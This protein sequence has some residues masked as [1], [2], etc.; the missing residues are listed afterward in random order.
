MDVWLQ[1]MGKDLKVGE[2]I[3]LKLVQGPPIQT[4][5][6][7]VDAKAAP[8]AFP[9]ILKFPVSTVTPNFTVAPW[10][11]G[12]LYQQDIPKPVEDSD[13]EDNADDK[14][15]KKRWKY[16]R[17]QAAKRQ[18]ILQEQVDFLETM[19]HRREAKKIKSTAESASSTN[20]SSSSSSSS[21]KSLSSRYEGVPE[22][23]A[24]QYVLLSLQTA[25]TATSNKNG[26]AD[27]ATVLV[28]H[29]PTPES[30]IAFQQPAARRTLT[31]SQAEQAIQDQRAGI[32]TTVRLPPLEFTKDQNKP[33]VA[34]LRIPPTKKNNSQSR[35]LQKLQKA[36]TSTDDAMEDGDDV[37]ADVT[38]RS[39][40]G[41]SG[42]GGGRNSGARR[43]LL[44]T[45]GDGLT[46]SDDGVL[47]GSNDAAFGGRLRFGK[48]Q[49]AATT[50]A[51]SGGDDHAERGADGAAMADDF[52]T[53]DVQAEYEELD[54]DANEQFDDDDVDLG[55]SEVQ[56][57]GTD[58]YGDEGDDEDD[59]DD[60]DAEDDAVSGAE[61]LATVAGFKALLA[62]ARGETSAI[63]ETNA[64][65][66]HTAN[67][68][69]EA[70]S[71]PP[72]SGTVSP[73]PDG[74]KKRD[75]PDETDHISKI[76]AAAE[77]SAQ[78]IKEKSKPNANPGGANGAGSGSVK[79]VTGAT[80]APQVDENGLRIIT[81]EAVRRE[82]WLNRG[83]IPIN[84]LIN[85]FDAKKKHGPDRQ[86]KFRDVVKELCTMTNDPVNGR[87]LVL[88]QHYAQMG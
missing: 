16:N 18:W 15:N 28:R 72:K 88:K 17:V 37:M 36:A 51:G 11:C 21:S 32:V 65:T 83:S 64:D 67:G 29:L 6:D 87:T 71:A 13:E 77:K 66:P 62:K 14:T 70:G 20:A 58:G 10:N 7:P 57:V 34:A 84:R 42:G 47:G 27:A 86:A 61:G 60:A 33:A 76:M 5:A 79:D 53:R 39:R 30:T 19:L 68:G 63:S 1:R 46:V 85:L 43:E 12:R 78:A 44:S 22:H 55:E 35:L 59:I 38:F 40:K 41:G 2:Q 82:I 4:T 49:V 23:N 74:I 56:A 80:S 31:L 3:R 24:S 25:G 9:A 69:G 54:Y 48:F 26:D 50:T 75:A 52:Y 73:K 81:V 45:L 8:E